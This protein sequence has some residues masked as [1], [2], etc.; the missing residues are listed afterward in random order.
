MEQPAAIVIG[1]ADFPGLNRRPIGPTVAE[2]EPLSPRLASLA[3]CASSPDKVEDGECGC[4]RQEVGV[5][6]V[7]FTAT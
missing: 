6:L 7:V 4:Q 1:R 2:G 3:K 5:V